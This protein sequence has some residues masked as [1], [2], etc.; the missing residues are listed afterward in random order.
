MAGQAGVSWSP[1][2]SNGGTPITGYTVTST[3]GGVTATTNGATSAVVTGLTNGTSYSFTV[4]ATNLVGSGPESVPSNSV[5]PKAVPGAPLNVTG[6]PGN[7]E[8]TVSWNAPASDGGSAIT[9]YIVTSS[10]GDTMMIV[11]ATTAVFSGL[12]NGTAY[13]FTVQAKN[14]VGVGPASAPSSPVTPVTLPGAPTGVTARP[15]NQEATVHWT[16][17]EETGGSPISGY[18]VVSI[19]DGVMAM[20]VGTTSTVVTGL[21]N[22]RSYTFTVSALNV[23]GAGAASG[24]SN[25]VT[26]CTMP[27]APTDVIAVP[28]AGQA[29]VSWTAPATTGGA[30]ILGYSVIA[31]PG[32][33]SVTTSGASTATIGGLTNGQSYTF[34][35]TATNSAGTGPASAPSAAV[36]PIALPAAPTNVVAVPGNTELTVSWTAAISMGPLL[37]YTVTVSP[38]GAQLSTTGATTATISGLTNGQ[39]YRCT[40]TATNASGTGPPSAPS[41][42]A[43]PASVPGV[44]SNVTVIP[45]NA[46][47]TVSWTAPANGG[48]PITG[49]VVTAMPGGL[50]QTTGSATSLVFPGLT[51]GQSYTFTVAAVNAMGT[52]LPSSPSPAVV[53]ATVPA[54]PQVTSLV[55]GDGKVTVTWTAPGDGGSPITGYTV[56]A[57][58]S[59][60]KA[61]TTGATSVAVTGLTN[62]LV[63]TFTVTATNAVGTGPASAMSGAVVPVGL[64]G[65]PTNVSAAAGVGE[66]SLNWLAP[67]SDGG[68]P[69][70]L[71]TVTANPGGQ[72]AMSVGTSV[73]VTGLMAGASYTFTVSAANV[74]GSGP[75]STPTTPVTIPEVPGVPTGVMATVGNASA[76]VS[77]VA[78]VDDGGLPV[79]GYIVTAS[80]GGVMASIS[81]PGTSTTLAGLMNGTSYTLTVVAVN[82]V[83]DSAA[84]APSNPVTPA[85]IPNAPTAVS[86]VAG[87]GQAAVSWTAS[88]DDGGAAITGYTVTSNPGGFTATTTGATTANVIGLTNGTAYT[89]SVFATNAIGNGPSSTS[90]AVTPKG[91]PDAPT[92]VTA[93]PG[94]GSA[95]VSWVAPGNGGSPITLYTVTSNPGAIT[96]TTTGATTVTVPG[97]SAGQAYTF[98][99]QA[100]NTLGTSAA[101]AAST[102]VTIW[103]LPGAPTNVTATPGVEEATVS[104]S[105]PAN[106]GGT[107]ITGYTV[108]S[109]PGNVTATT[110][111]ATSVL[112]TGLANLTSYTFTV[113]AKNAVGNGP[114]SAASAAVTTVTQS[115][116][117]VSPTAITA[118]GHSFGTITATF[119]NAS[120]TALANTPV[121]IFVSGGGNMVLPP[122][123]TTNASGVFTATLRSTIAGPRTIIATAGGF[124]VSAT[125]SLVPVACKGALSFSSVGAT[126]TVGNTPRGL[127][128]A[129]FNQDGKLDVAE[130]NNGGTTVNVLLGNGT[131][132]L[133]NAAGSP[134]TTGTSPWGGAAADVNNDGLV[135]L[136]IPNYGSSTVS[137]L[138]GNGSGG[139]TA[140]AAVTVSGSPSYVAAGDFNQDG[141]LDFAASE[142]VAGAVGVF[143]GNG[144]GGFS[145]ATGSPIA[146]GSNP[147]A[148]VAADFNGDGILDIAS[149]NSGGG[150]VSI[151]LGNGS[152]GFTSA[153]AVGVGSGPGGLAAADFNGDGFVDLVSGNESSA[154]INV[155]LGNGSGGFSNASGS[156]IT[157]GN[158]PWF[159]APGDFDG[160]G[161]L[162]L[163]IPNW[164]SG[165]VSFL[166]GNGT[167]A[168]AGF[169]ISPFSVIS[170]PLLVSGDFNGDGKLDI[171]VASYSG[172]VVGIYLNT[173]P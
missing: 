17:P 49:Y 116:L 122:G 9:S 123:G 72:T 21:T 52:G 151:L 26:P 74:A 69:I 83:G 73:T 110:T 40:V 41:A 169:S 12:V 152:G 48:S 154:N 54:A 172:D 68:S 50:T 124:H 89:F 11:T 57:S 163:A 70:L 130:M 117:T 160:D 127:A 173:C 102:P 1:P 145:Q 19:P 129:D 87:N 13:T 67:A 43:T 100:T 97:L 108:T 86:A 16:A 34:V 95:S 168:F 136:I 118:D 106:T 147:L 121:S 84:S 27:D 105:A 158:V 171:A 14:G 153:P 42:A 51:N 29:T 139:F 2:A 36:T 128:V 135:D 120:G 162:D 38:G 101:S 59:M 60:V 80:P 156:P 82:A 114:S 6:L 46:A 44:P 166:K 62:G 75:S 93:T 132:G 37:G 65:M 79:T 157:V 45:G 90:T 170:D 164:N 63:Y 15:G 92:G 131:G 77:W 20:A 111:G 161:Y 126:V 141:K 7:E 103:S 159:P 10:P 143:L 149:E 109:S 119:T 104:W 28:G 64:P 23:A 99:V 91:A 107:V 155:L 30:P 47:V 25:A 24:P 4:H 146:T 55:A 3:P 113:F 150:S 22:G 134:I 71:Y 165:T 125:V 61:T 81:A 115:G 53:P 32:G 112:V 8:A 96:A 98:T 39:S 94:V 137:I 167:G 76:S 35:V 58:P 5:N 66:A 140:A 56:I 88:T 78:P 133:S 33:T 18:L 148:I 144:S 138:L 31:S 142:S 85:T